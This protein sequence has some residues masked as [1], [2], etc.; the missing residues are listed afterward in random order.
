MKKSERIF[1]WDGD[2]CLISMIS[3]FIIYINQH[4]GLK[5]KY[6]DFKSFSYEE[7]IGI[8]EEDMVKI[9]RQFYESPLYNE[10]KP[11]EGALEVVEYCS[12]NFHMPVVTGRSQCDEKY[13]IR[14]L[15]KLFESHHFGA[16]FHVGKNHERGLA[17]PKWKKCK[18]IGA[19]LII[20]DS[21]NTVID[22]G[23]NEVHGILVEAPWNRRIIELPKNVYKA[24]TIFEVPDIIHRK[25]KIIW[26]EY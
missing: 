6:E 11:K 10:I 24:R 17:I 5:L 22:A 15:D 8:P 3:V 9:E 7:S 19:R 14:T 23:Q 1:V 25:E 2:E 16:I 21:A 13:L 26:P 12:G 4:Y 18:E 20:D